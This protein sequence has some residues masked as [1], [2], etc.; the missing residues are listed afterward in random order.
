M[1][2]EPMSPLAE[3]A[4]DLAA[5]AEASGGAVTAA[6]VPLPGAG[7]P[8]RLHGGLGRPGAAARAQ[9]RARGGRSGGPV[10]RAGRVVHHGVRRLGTGHRG[11]A[12]GGPRRR[13]LLDRGRL[14]EP[15]RARPV[16]PCSP[17]RAGAGMLPRPAPTQLVGGRLR[18]D[19]PGRE[20]RSS[21]I[22]AR[23]RRGSTCA[24]RS[25]ATSSIGSRTPPPRSDAVPDR[26]CRGRDHD[27]R[28]EVEVELL[29]VGHAEWARAR[30]AVSSSSRSHEARARPP[31]QGP[32]TRRETLYG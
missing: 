8:P 26:M 13:S 9:H 10:A 20:P 21:W 19:D 5:L 31:E 2:V 4:R 3:R 6:E 30:S 16:R 29:G 15:C 28:S 1:T 18:P 25:R 7:R 12:R 27:A 24:L 32:G 14:R 22:N 11:G 17:R 23:T